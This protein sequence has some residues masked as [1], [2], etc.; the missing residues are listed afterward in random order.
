MKTF[1]F[2]TFVFRQFQLFLLTAVFLV[3]T[4]CVSYG[5]VDGPYEGKV[6]DAQTGQPIEGAVV[7]GVWNKAH[8]GAG[9]A[10]HTYYDSCEVLTDSNGT[11][12]IQGLGMLLLSK[13]EEMNITI[14]KAGYEQLGQRTWHSLRLSKKGYIQWEG[15]NPT[16]R[17]KK[18]SIEE[19]LKRGVELP[20]VSNNKQKR[21]IIE[22]NK[23]M[24]EI[25]RPSNTLLPEE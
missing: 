19:R 20:N 16:I 7:F 3:S 25:G 1:Q 22:R 23:E 18:L 17:L 11:F 9:G 13:I 21:L 10:S 2:F 5:R 15:N 4:G 12:S 8:P 6:I 24:V 14:F